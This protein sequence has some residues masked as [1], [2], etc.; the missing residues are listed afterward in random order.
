MFESHGHTSV[1]VDGAH[2]SVI[3]RGLFNL[4]GCQQFVTLVGDAVRSLG[5]QPFTMLIDNLEFEGGTPEAYR[6]LDR[7]NAWLNTRPLVAK[8]MLRRSETL[9]Q[10]MNTLA[11]SRQK[12]N[13]RDFADR[14]EAEAWLREQLAGHGG[15]PG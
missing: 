7:F 5:E 1:S 9:M 8:A 13:I 6:E 3:A 10:I 14:D 11:P 12:Q 15:A 2:I 4:D